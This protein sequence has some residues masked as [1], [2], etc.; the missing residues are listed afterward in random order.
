MAASSSVGQAHGSITFDQSLRL[1]THMWQPAL[2]LD[3]PK[4]NLEKQQCWVFFDGNQ[5]SSLTSYA[6][7]MALAMMENPMKAVRKSP[8]M[9]GAAD[10][11]TRP[12][13]IVRICSQHDMNR[14]LNATGWIILSTLGMSRFC[15]LCYRL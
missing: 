14:E 11:D 5:F 6:Q 8:Q 7:N 13:L 15:S 10:E 2:Q 1:A 12:N 4:P 9:R 3:R